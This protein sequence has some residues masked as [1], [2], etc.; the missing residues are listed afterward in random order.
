MFPFEYFN[1]VKVVFGE[2]Q[3]EKSLSHLVLPNEKVFVCSGQGSAERSGVLAKVRAALGSR[4]VGEFAGIE[5][6]PD[7]ETLAEASKQARAADAT[8]ILAVGGGSVIDGVKLIAAQAKLNLSD[9]WQIVTSRG[10]KVTDALPYGAVLTLSATGSEMNSG[11]VVSRKESGEKK[12]FQS[13]LVFPRFSIID[14]SVMLSLP[15]RQVVNGIVDPYVHVIEQY[16]TYPVQAKLQE[17]QAEAILSVLLEESPK[18]IADLTNLEARKNLIWAATSALNGA[19]G[20]GVPQDWSTHLIGHELTARWGLDHAQSLAVVLPSLLRFAA[21]SKGQMLQQ[22]GERVFHLK[23]S[24][25]RLEAIQKT[26]DFFVSVGAPTKLSSYG[27]SSTEWESLAS[28]L[29]KLY[30]HGIG[31]KSAIKGHNFLTILKGCA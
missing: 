18:V 8:F 2:Q 25:V 1:P 15:L 13:P 6:N 24:D 26:E 14:P 21:D 22:Y 9:P 30:P 28:D 29:A 19:I 16:L 4:I 12:S 23:G 5:P 17:R 27:I 11:S 7:I 20:V 10:R 3:I 31:E